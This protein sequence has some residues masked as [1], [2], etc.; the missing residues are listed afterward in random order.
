MSA[1]DLRLER[2]RRSEDNTKCDPLDTL[3]VAHEELSAGS[4]IRKMVLIVETENPDGSI[5]LDSFR[6]GVTR[7][8][9]IALLRLQETS[10]MEKWR[11]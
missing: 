7:Y 9:E 2:I 5:G 10:T 11:R 1:V 8:E 4:P 6:A 3:L